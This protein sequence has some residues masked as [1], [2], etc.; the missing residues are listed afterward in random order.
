MIGINDLLLLIVITFLAVS[1]FRNMWLSFQLDETWPA[2]DGIVYVFRTH[3]RQDTNSVVHGEPGIRC[4]Y[5]VNGVA[6]IL[7]LDNFISN[8]CTAHQESNS[9]QSFKRH[10]R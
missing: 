5:K 7:N 6:H 9:R 10:S 4:L 3:I 1:G 8:N 2:V